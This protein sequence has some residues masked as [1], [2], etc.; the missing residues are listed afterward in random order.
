MPCTANINFRNTEFLGLSLIAMPQTCDGIPFSRIHIPT[1]VP[2]GL[3]SIAWYVLQHLA[4]KSHSKW[5]IGSAPS[6][7]ARLSGNHTLSRS[8]SRMAWEI[9]S[10]SIPIQYPWSLTATRKH[11]GMSCLMTTPPLP[12]APREPTQQPHSWRLP[13]R[14]LHLQLGL[15]HLVDDE[16]SAT[17]HPDRRFW[18]LEFWSFGILEFE[19]F[20]LSA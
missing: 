15:T 19:S 20:L 9:K 7:G 16:Y 12:A 10:C 17:L 6:H 1:S 8:M 13:L 5:N 4:F 14:L 2:E 3:M 11:P 18:I